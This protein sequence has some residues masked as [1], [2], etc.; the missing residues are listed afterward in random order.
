VPLFLSA[1]QRSAG[2]TTSPLSANTRQRPCKISI[3]RTDIAISGK[4]GHALAF[5]AELR[6][7]LLNHAPG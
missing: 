4:P 5:G 3:G 2:F 1:A 6:D 7:C